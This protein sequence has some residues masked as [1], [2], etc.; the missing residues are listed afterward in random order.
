MII[1]KSVL[2]FCFL[3]GIRGDLGSYFGIDLG[4]DV[5]INLGI[6]LG[7]DLDIE[8]RIDVGNQIS[9]IGYLRCLMRPWPLLDFRLSHLQQCDLVNHFFPVV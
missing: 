7:N 2:S 3:V 9:L 8:L 4:I 5:R 1:Q 6:K